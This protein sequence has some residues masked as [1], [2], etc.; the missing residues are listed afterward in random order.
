M[1]KKMKEGWDEKGAGRINE[2]ACPAV[3]GTLAA[4]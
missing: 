4:P 1:Q 2:T 3:L